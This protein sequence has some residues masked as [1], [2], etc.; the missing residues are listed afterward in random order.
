[1]IRSFLI[2]ERNG[3][4]VCHRGWK[5]LLKTPTIQNLVSL[6][7]L[8]QLRTVVGNTDVILSVDNRDVNMDGIIEEVR[9][10]YEAI[11]Q[12]SKAEV[13]AMYQGRV[14]RHQ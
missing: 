7:E 11:A 2:C 9:Q 6:Q 10:E 14:S 12:R 1:M 4:L 13:D 5:R 3:S 8:S